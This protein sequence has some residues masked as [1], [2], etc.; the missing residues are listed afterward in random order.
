MK[1]Q[2]KTIAFIALVFSLTFATCGKRICDKKNSDDKNMSDMDNESPD[3][4]LKSGNYESKVSVTLEKPIDYEFYTKGTIEYSLNGEIAAVVNYGDGEMDSWATKTMNGKT[5]EFDM[6][7]K[8]S[9][10]KKGDY[11][12]KIVKPLVKTENCKYIVEGIIKYFKDGKWVSTV[13]YGDGT[14]DDIATKTWK[15]G[16]KTFSLSGKK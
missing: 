16:S 7:K 10:D 1:N 15:D 3:L 2:F 9:K 6:S 11:D 14:C 8:C 13:D 5:E 4:M 12:K